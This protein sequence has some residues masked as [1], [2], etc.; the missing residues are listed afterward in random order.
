MRKPKL[1][2]SIEIEEPFWADA[3]IWTCEVFSYLMSTEPDYFK[4]HSFLALSA[5]VK[6]RK[7]LVADETDA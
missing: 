6:V 1:A 7:Y 3:Y 4:I 2:I 5:T